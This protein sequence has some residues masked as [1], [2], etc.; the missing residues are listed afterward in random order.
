MV[1]KVSAPELPLVIS[2]GHILEY[3]QLVA[4][5]NSLIIEIQCTRLVVGTGA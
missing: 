3:N 4:S 2:S 5:D 1:D